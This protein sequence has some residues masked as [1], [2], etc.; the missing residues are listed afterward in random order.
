MERALYRSP[1]ALLELMKIRLSL[2]IAFTATVGFLLQQPGPSLSLA[3]VTI[4]VFL[5]ATGAA[6]LNNVQDHQRDAH[7]ARTRSRALPSGRIDRRS[8]MLQGTLMMALGLATL[9]L[10]FQSLLPTILGLASVILY[11]LVYTPLK[12][13]TILAIIPGAACG[14]LPPYIGWLA[15]GGDALSL[16]ILLI[17]LMMGIWQVPH[18]WIILL[19]HQEDHHGMPPQPNILNRI[20][21]SRLQQTT[22]VWITT[23]ACLSLLP[24]LFGM[25]RTLLPALLLTANAMLL[26]TVSCFTLCRTTPVKTRFLHT[27]LSTSLITALTLISLGSN[28]EL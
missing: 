6:S 1:S 2:T 27:F 10:A 18:Y 8:A 17:M 7:C 20:H 16:Q 14:M 19:K 22:F 3:A 25:T 9:S 12:S 5:L 24:I 11:N 15:G 28:L 21:G 4:G 23:F 26:V 13:R